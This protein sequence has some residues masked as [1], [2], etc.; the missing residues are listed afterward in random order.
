[1]LVA[2]FLHDLEPF[3]DLALGEARAPLLLR[4]RRPNLKDRT[5]KKTLCYVD[6]H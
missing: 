4:L 3:S 5:K 2:G 1:M 6:R